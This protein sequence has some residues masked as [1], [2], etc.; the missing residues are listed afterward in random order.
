M[1]EGPRYRVQ[2]RRRREGLTD[3]RQRLKL[4]LSDR[5]RAVVRVSNSRV[6]VSLTVFD[7][8]GDRVVAAAS[9]GELAAIG[10]PATSLRS[11][12]A[13]YLTGYLAGLRAKA[14]GATNAVLDAGLRHPTPGGR[15]ISA[16]KGLVDAGV[17]VPHGDPKRF[18]TNDRLNGKHLRTPLATP[19]EAFKGKLPGIVPRGE[20]TA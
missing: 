6:L 12:P 15:V 17:E 14:S 2:F 3:Y 10:F 19:L 13:A 20:A 11:T 1:S 5:P 16:V 8:V 7:P 4:L 18:P 9:S